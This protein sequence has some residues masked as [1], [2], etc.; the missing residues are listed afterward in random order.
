MT[1]ARIQDLP[2]LVG[3]TVTLQG[4]LYNR[5]SKGKLVFLQVR[6]GTGICQCVVFR[7]NVGDEL[8]AIADKL[9]LESS[10]IITGTVRADARA[11]GVPGGYELDV[12]TLQVVHRAEEY[13]IGPKEHG[14]EFLMDHRHLWIRSSR[15]WAV[16]RV[17]ATVMRAIRAWLDAHGF[18][19]VTTP[20]LTPSAA[21][22]TTTLFEVD[23]FGEKAH[24]RKP[25]ALQRGDDLLVRARTASVRRS[26]PRRAKHAATSPSSGWWSRR[27][28]SATS[29]NC[30]RSRSSS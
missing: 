28:P 8:F 17:R 12:Q 7:P 10:L 30:L 15:Q 16:L 14:V 20:I 25:A 5:T 23:Y 3:E 18:L 2:R 1:L 24:L 9:T 6:D 22:G 11:P 26:A 27:S 19:E 4:W 29:I 21:E 13:P